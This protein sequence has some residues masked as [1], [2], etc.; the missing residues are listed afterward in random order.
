MRFEWR[1]KFRQDVYLRCR[2]RFPPCLCVERWIRMWSRDKAS[3]VLNPA[4]RRGPGNSSDQLIMSVG[5]RAV[6][7]EPRPWRS[8]ASYCTDWAIPAHE[9][10]CLWGIQGNYSCL[11]VF[12]TSARLRVGTRGIR[13]LLVTISECSCSEWGTL[14]F[15]FCCSFV[16]SVQN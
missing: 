16:F 14:D 6:T 4:Y 8:S 10:L 13:G 12:A 11:Q 5:G 7:R 15:V 1:L 2:V 3:R 9:L